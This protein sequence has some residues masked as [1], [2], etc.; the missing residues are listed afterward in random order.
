V[1]LRIKGNSLRLRLSKSE[2]ETLET[3]GRVE[4]RIQFGPLDEQQLVYAIAAP[5][6]AEDLAVRYEPNRITVEIPREAATTWVSTDL[7][8]F[9]EEVR[10]G[11]TMRL[12]VLLEKDFQCLTEREGEDESDNFANPHASCC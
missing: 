1:K 9:S 2:I 11:A 4:D 6:E 12:R 3:E 7:V 5:V 8:G 10:V